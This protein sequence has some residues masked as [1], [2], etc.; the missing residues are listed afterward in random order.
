M[1]TDELLQ[2]LRDDLNKIINVLKND[3]KALLFLAIAIFGMMVTVSYFSYRDA[4]QY[5]EPQ[6][7]GLTQQLKRTQYQL[8]RASDDRAR[9]TK[10][11]AELTGNGG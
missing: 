1:T 9:Q 2:N 6:I 3:W 5:Y 8:K 11:I 7:T 4:R 10:R